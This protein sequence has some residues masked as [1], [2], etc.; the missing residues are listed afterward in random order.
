MTIEFTSLK[1]ASASCGQPLVYTELVTPGTFARHDCSN[2]QPARCSCS[3]GPW[4]TGPAINT[5]FLSAAVA[6]S[7]MTIPKTQ[8]IFF[9]LEEGEIVWFKAFSG[10]GS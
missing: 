5:T 2:R 4:L 7:A 9:M 10:A 3:P 1:A 8:R 6:L